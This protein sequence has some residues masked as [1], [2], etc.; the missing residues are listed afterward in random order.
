MGVGPALGITLGVLVVYM[1]AGWLLSLVRKDASVVDPFWGLGFIVAAVSYFLLTHGYAGR[2]VLVVAMVCVWGVRLAAYIVWRNRGRG[3][4]P[5]YQAMRAKRPGS[6][7]WY[8]YFQVFL[9]QALLLWLVAAPIAA[10]IGG[11]ADPGF[12]VLDIVGAVVWF[13]GLLWEVVGDAQLAHFR[14]EPANKGKVLQSG[15]WRYT[16]HPNY[17]GE[18]LLWWGVW[19][20]AAAAH[21]YWS[22][23]GPL[24]LTL[25]LLR[26]SGVTLLEKSLKESKPEYQE[27]ARRTSSFVPWFPRRGVEE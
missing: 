2:R 4:D 3:E 20:V 19:L 1:T 21:G 27:Y 7:W 22:V 13:F 11:K 16:R 6:F 25:L 18:A 23:Y 15:V 5:R 8:S 14:R 10:A 9:L 12:T 17:F 26:V 24:L